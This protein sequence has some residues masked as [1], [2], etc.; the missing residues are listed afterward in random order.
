MLTVTAKEQRSGQQASVE[1]KAAHGLSQ[2]E[3]ERMVLESVDHAH[4]D[5]TQ[6]RFIELKNKADADLRHTGKALKSLGDAVSVEDRLAIENAIVHLESAMKG[7]DVDALQRAVDAFGQAT[8]ALAEQQM[9]ANVK[10]LLAG[11]REDEIKPI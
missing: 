3:V 2:D 6:R 9:N 10:A 5:F 1:V 8:A 4:E 11:K 7:N